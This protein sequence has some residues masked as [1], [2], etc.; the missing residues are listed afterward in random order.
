MN[1]HQT[2]IIQALDNMRGDDSARARRAF[3]GMTRTQMNEQHGQSGKTRGQILS[4]YEAHDAK[5]DAAIVWVRSV[6]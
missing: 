5:I 3:Y 2:L 1:T 4:E 6:R